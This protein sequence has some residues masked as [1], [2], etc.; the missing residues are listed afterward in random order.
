MKEEEEN[1]EEII[2]EEVVEET[3]EETTT[4]ET[5]S[6]EDEEFDKNIENLSSEYKFDFTYSTENVKLTLENNPDITVEELHSVYPEFPDTK[7]LK[8]S[9]NLAVSNSDDL[10]KKEET[11]FLSAV[12]GDLETSDLGT[13]STLNLTSSKIEETEVEETTVEEDDDEFSKELIEKHSLSTL[14]HTQKYITEN[15]ALPTEEK[16]DELFNQEAYDSLLLLKEEVKVEEEVEKHVVKPRDGVRE[17]EDGS[18]STHIMKTEVLD[19]GTWVS[20]PMLFQ[21]EDGTWVE[22]YE[23][24][25]EGYE[26]SWDDFPAYLEAKTRGE[27]YEFGDDKDAAIAFGEGSWKTEEEV[28]EITTDFDADKFRKGINTVEASGN[29]DYSLLPTDDGKPYV[30]GENKLLSSAV[31]P[32]QFLYSVHKDILKSKFG[33][34]SKEEFI[35]NEEAQ[36]GLMDYMLED[37]PGR[38]TFMA[39]ALEEKY[40]EQIKKLGLSNTDLMGMEHFVGHGESRKLFAKVRDGD[41]TKEEFFETI[42]GGLNNSIGTY[43]EKYRG[44]MVVEEEGEGTGFIFPEDELLDYIIARK[45][46]EESTLTASVDPSF[47][48]TEKPVD[49]EYLYLN[50]T[51]TAKAYRNNPNDYETWHLRLK[52]KQE[53]ATILYIPGDY[54]TIDV[55]GLKNINYKNISD[56]QKDAVLRYLD[57]SEESYNSIVSSKNGDSALNMMILGWYNP[58]ISKLTLSPTE[59][60][61]ANAVVKEILPGRFFSFNDAA[62]MDGSMV[63]PEGTYYF[64][65]QQKEEYGVKREEAKERGFDEISSSDQRKI[66]KVVKSFKRN[67]KVFE[68]VGKK[69]ELKEVELDFSDIENVIG[70]SE[71]WEYYNNP[72]WYKNLYLNDKDIRTAP[73]NVIEDLQR[74]IGVNPDGDFG[75]NS[76]VAMLLFDKYDIQGG[77]SDW[78]FLPAGQLPQ[79]V[80]DWSGG[81]WSGIQGPLLGRT[82]SDEEGGYME[83]WQPNEFDVNTMLNYKL[84]FL[85]E[86]SDDLK[87][88]HN[89]NDKTLD[90]FF[91]L[92]TT[93]TVDNYDAKKLSVHFFSNYYNEQLKELSYSDALNWDWM[94][95]KQDILLKKI[96]SNAVEKTFQKFLDVKTMISIGNE[97]NIKLY[98]YLDFIGYDT[99]GGYTPDKEEDDLFVLLKEAGLLEEGVLDFSSYMNSRDLEG[100]DNPNFDNLKSREGDALGGFYENVGVYIKEIKMQNGTDA[101]GSGEYYHASTFNLDKYDRNKK[102]LFTKKGVVFEI[103]KDSQKYSGSEIV[104]QE[105]IFPI[106]EE[107]QVMLDAQGGVNSKIDQSI[108][109]GLAMYIRASNV[110][111]DDRQIANLFK[112]KKDEFE[113]MLDGLTK[114]VIE[115]IPVEYFTET[116]ST[117]V[118]SGGF[119]IGEPQVGEK[120]TIQ[121]QMGWDHAGA[122]SEKHFTPIT[123]S[124]QVFRELN[125]YD[126]VSND[127]HFGLT[128]KLKEFNKHLMQNN[129]HVGSFSNI[130]DYQTG[131]VGTSTIVQ[132]GGYG[133]TPIAMSSRESGD[134]DAPIGARYSK[135]FIY[136]DGKGSWERLK[137]VTNDTYVYTKELNEL[138]MIIGHTIEDRKQQEFVNLHFESIV[139]GMDDTDDDEWVGF[140]AAVTYFGE[141][142]PFR[143]KSIADINVFRNSVNTYLAK[144]FPTLGESERHMLGVRLVNTYKSLQPDFIEKKESLFL[145]AVQKYNESEATTNSNLFPTDSPQTLIDNALKEVETLREEGIDD[146]AIN[147]IINEKYHCDINIYNGQIELNDKYLSRYNQ[148]MYDV[149]NDTWKW[150]N[151]NHVDPKSTT[152]EGFEGTMGIGSLYYALTGGKELNP[153]YGHTYTPMERIYI[154]ALSIMGD[155]VMYGLGWAAKASSIRIMGKGRNALYNTE[156][157]MIQN[158]NATSKVIYQNGVATGRLESG[159]V[160]FKAAQVEAQVLI[161]NQAAKYNKYTS[162]IQNQLNLGS[163]MGAAQVVSNLKENQQPLNGVGEAAFDGVKI[164]TLMWGLN[165]YTN[166]AKQYLNAK[167][168]QG[169]ILSQGFG[170]VSKFGVNIASINAEAAIFTV[171]GHHA[172]SATAEFATIEEANKFMK[173]REGSELIESQ[174]QISVNYKPTFLDNFV[175]NLKLISTLHGSRAVFN[176]GKI[177]AKPTGKYGFKTNLA[178]RDFATDFIK[179]HPEFSAQYTELSK[180]KKYVDENGVLTDRGLYTFID[181]NLKNNIKEMQANL[182]LVE[183]SET[184]QSVW[185]GKNSM[186]TSELLSIFSPK[187]MNSYYNTY[188]YGIMGGVYEDDAYTDDIAVIWKADGSGKV[189][190]KNGNRKIDEVTGEEIPN[191]GA[192]LAVVDAKELGMTKE[193]QNEV[194]D[195]WLNQSKKEQAQS[196]INSGGMGSNRFN[197]TIVE[198]VSKELK[199]KDI[200][201][202]DINN[203][204]NDKEIAGNENINNQIV[205]A[206]NNKYKEKIDLQNKEINSNEKAIVDEAYNNL[207]DKNLPT[208]TENVIEEVKL[209]TEKRDI[210]KEKEQVIKVEEKRVEGDKK[211]QEEEIKES[212]FYE[213]WENTD[214]TITTNEGSGSKPKK[215]N[216]ESKDVVKI[217]SDIDGNINVDNAKRATIQHLENTG[218]ITPELK[219]SI[220]GAKTYEDVK[221][222]IKETSIQGFEYKTPRQISAET[223]GIGQG[224]TLDVLNKDFIVDRTKYESGT[225]ITLE[226][227]DNM[228]SQARS[229]NEIANLESIKKSLQEGKGAKYYI[230]NEVGSLEKLAKEE[231]KSV[232][233]VSVEGYTDKNGN[234]HF[235]SKIA[236]STTATHEIGHFDFSKLDKPTRERLQKDMEKVMSEEIQLAG[237]EK[238]VNVK[239]KDG[240]DIYEGTK[241]EE[242]LMRLAEA[243]K[244]G[245]IDPKSLE[246]LQSNKYLNNIKVKINTMLKYL[247]VDPLKTNS[248]ALQ[249]ASDYVNAKNNNFKP[250]KTDNL[251]VLPVKGEEVEGEGEGKLKV[252]EIPKEKFEIDKKKIE[253]TGFEK[254]V[255][256]FQDRID[257]QKDKLIKEESKLSTEEVTEI[258]EDIKFFENEIKDLTEIN[259]FETYNDYKQSLSTEVVS[260]PKRLETL[261]KELEVLKSENADQ[262]LIDAK[263]I[264]INSARVKQSQSEVKIETKETTNIEDIA[265]SEIED[266]LRREDYGNQTPE[267]QNEIIHDATI[268]ILDKSGIYSTNKDVKYLPDSKYTKP[269]QDLIRQLRLLSKSTNPDVTGKLNFIVSNIIKGEFNAKEVRDFIIERKADEGGF[270]LGD[271]IK[272]ADN[273]YR[274]KFYGIKFELDKIERDLSL[275]P[276]SLIESRLNMEKGGEINKYIIGPVQVSMKNFTVNTREYLNDWN[277]LSKW[278]SLKGNIILPGTSKLNPLYIQKKTRDSKLGILAIQRMFNAGDLTTNTNKRNFVNEILNNPE[279]LQQYTKFDRNRLIAAY[280]KLPKKIEIID[281]KEVEVIDMDKAMSNLTSK[282][283]KLLDMFD[284]TMLDMRDKQKLSNEMNG[285]DFT[286]IEFYTPLIWLG[287]KTIKTEGKEITVGE[288]M[289]IGNKESENWLNDQYKEGG[290]N[291]ESERGIERTTNEIGP[292]V[293]DINKMFNNVVRKTNREYYLGNTIN[294]VQSIFKEARHPDNTTLSG[295]TII[296][297]VEGR[298]KDAV[299]L[300]LNEANWI[301]KSTMQKVLG[302]AYGV[303]LLRPG[304]LLVEAAVEPIRV[305]VGATPVTDIPE[306][307]RDSYEQG[308]S[309]ALSLV[310]FNNKLFGIGPKIDTKSTFQ[311]LIEI[312]DSPYLIKNNR[313]S[314]EYSTELTNDNGFMNRQAQFFH[315]LTDRNTLYMAYMPAFR[316]HFKKTTGENF[317]YSEFNNNPEYASKFE[318]AI[319]ES[320]AFGDRSAGQWKNIALKG[321]GRTKVRMPFYQQ[322]SSKEKF[323]IP[324]LT[325]MSSFGALES[326]MYSK[327][328]RDIYRGETAADKIDG[329]KRSTSI[330][331]MG[332]SY[333]LGVTAE[334][335]TYKYGAE[336]LHLLNKEENDWFGEGGQDNI[337]FT[338]KKDQIVND[339]KLEIKRLYSPEYLVKSSILNASFLARTRYSQASTILLSIGGGLLWSMGDADDKKQVVKT[340]GDVGF[341]KPTKG[342]TDEFANIF[343]PSIQEVL[344]IIQ[345]DLPAMMD[346]REKFSNLPEEAWNKEYMEDLLLLNQIHTISRLYFMFNGTAMMGDKQ[347]KKYLDGE[348]ATFGFN[349]TDIAGSYDEDGAWVPSREPFQEGYSPL[350]ITREEDMDPDVMRLIERDINSLYIK[351]MTSEEIEDFIKENEFMLDESFSVTPNVNK[352]VDSD[353]AFTLPDI[354]DVEVDDEVPFTL[355]D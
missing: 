88:L 54:T 251:T 145:D 178:E 159:V 23:G 288:D 231:G 127:M 105:M 210:Q 186:K 190:F 287:G 350:T 212:R 30:S 137:D 147:E 296:T 196:I 303:K 191:T 323:V 134:S 302:Y 298:I 321:Q 42:P 139:K 103:E 180:T 27:V 281:G 126:L 49:W 62:N 118:S 194:V 19:D 222:L 216:I 249:W 156:K 317:N 289:Q 322:I 227:I 261:V 97:D 87:N 14:E 160:G 294:E 8:A 84:Q 15:W 304:R 262:S 12:T 329:L 301:G 173:G 306:F 116:Y 290:L 224:T 295:Q 52:Q 86:H 10:K 169:G 146:I 168:G 107:L 98:E 344:N 192:T 34:N 229:S 166:P 297:A 47:V 65:Q 245:D 223:T 353:D 122:F 119:T 325:F 80:Q 1:I 355:P 237:I 185:S 310:T 247:G 202:E 50:K 300:H 26:G 255:E 125:G 111:L 271:A 187:T 121:Y 267:R 150:Y 89:V 225:E 299:D 278:T 234:I 76:Y 331:T 83:G 9:I 175:E 193:N 235:S 226:N 283:V 232:E 343:L 73:K 100:I 327:G 53:L 280:N 108:F 163:Y 257:F 18:E 115:D 221:G 200:T 11:T 183:G 286:D 102:V 165:I 113:F 219:K 342:N 260:E 182:E 336:Y 284:N 209:I 347:M 60:V 104:G 91:S 110:T 272:N 21:D 45:E 244:R 351:D 61:Q 207:K 63:F 250:T 31:G 170:E 124:S 211:F 206:V 292:Y 184:K 246:G 13:H 128:E 181:G 72:E 240:N 117:G 266:I 154:T 242:A 338:K 259:K 112:M 64:A 141:R 162:L 326:A 316:H 248:E 218:E 5:I 28:K 155:P 205:E 99:K 179:N 337:E 349:W 236:E 239:D 41:I 148:L 293:L 68:E 92:L 66:N 312:T 256:M 164:G 6:L 309:N 67:F 268:E 74:V 276:L 140:Q 79:S 109:T 136:R 197:K 341:I 274:G 230:H 270:Y 133:D 51:S 291:L 258:K 132:T 213:V 58:L 93:F 78:G 120:R 201:I 33:V 57:I 176:I 17:N 265:T 167:F 177:N 220:E 69:R 130:S 315:G 332:V 43:L 143:Q 198:E 40:S 253:E 214:G 153:D 101:R 238:Q 7:T 152:W 36:E 85:E 46:Q 203:F 282:E 77:E 3:I 157:G 305:G 71:I 252:T 189:I 215:V 319:I 330:F 149:T 131:K 188:G 269:Q 106:S 32:Y 313:W 273:L 195:F 55:H 285:K 22:K 199:D 144:E 48:T 135:V 2:T 70:K 82:W 324:S 307:M 314:M 56:R 345:K 228:I 328:I 29:M 204:I 174:G 75:F 44:G 320:S 161:S 24:T 95:D 333:G 339:Y 318:Q 277:K 39:N 158:Y 243:I 20:F 279:L 335:I 311:K 142:N 354:D 217:E 35:G 208:T 171:V 348:F 37:K 96:V 352:S 4:E 81:N 114:E 241:G 94:G 138:Q 25:D 129:I 123:T 263:Q 90:E 340:L 38:Y 59:M 308:R 334:F 254:Q 233:E 264:E 151:E 16:P 346:R 275:Y 172:E